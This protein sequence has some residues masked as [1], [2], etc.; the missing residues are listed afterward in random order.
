MDMFKVSIKDPKNRK[1]DPPVVWYLHERQED[2]YS[3]VNQSVSQINVYRVRDRV[4][5]N[6]YVS[7]HEIS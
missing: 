2:Q 3:L 4:N 7:A 1:V 6:G 5:L